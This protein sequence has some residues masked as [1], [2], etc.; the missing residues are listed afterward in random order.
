MLDLET[1]MIEEE[2]RMLQKVFP[3]YYYREFGNAGS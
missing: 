1:F 2:K 3:E